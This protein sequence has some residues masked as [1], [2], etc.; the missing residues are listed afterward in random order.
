MQTINLKRLID[1][2]NLQADASKE[3]ISKL[4]QEAKTYGFNSICI[5][6][7]WVK[8][9]SN[10][11]KCCTVTSFPK[12]VFNI[13]SINEVKDKIGNFS[14]EEKSQEFRQAMLDRAFEIDPV[15]NISNLDNLK[16]ELSV[17]YDA[18][19][20]LAI[21]VYIK[22]IFSCEILS[23][24]ELEFSIAKFSEFARVSQYE[25]IKYC[26]KNSTGFI[27]SEN[28]ELLKT[29][30]TEL[31]TKI[32]KYFDIYD[33]HEVVSF[34]IAGGIRSLQDIEHY[35]EICGDRLSHIGTSSGV[36]IFS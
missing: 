16:D 27:K 3:D 25:N 8:E 12:E 9:F 23:D 18:V 35:H 7:K 29:I 1:H 6:P 19:M 21:G 10:Q 2:T 32:K 5:R 14:Y 36:K 13:S 4:A 31:V 24:D 30:S 34:K 26:Y 33:P 20:S 15:I 17:Y 11:Y 22:P 28:P